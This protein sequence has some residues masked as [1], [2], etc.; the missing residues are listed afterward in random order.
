MRLWKNEKNIFFETV[1]SKVERDMVQS[2][3]EYVE[4]AHTGS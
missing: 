3:E 2:K 4:L 1:G